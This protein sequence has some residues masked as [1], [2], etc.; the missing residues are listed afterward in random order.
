MLATKLI[1]GHE[2]DVA[3]PVRFG[4][5]QVAHMVNIGASNQIRLINEIEMS[6]SSSFLE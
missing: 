2:L 4:Q 5:S 3:S 1:A 6:P